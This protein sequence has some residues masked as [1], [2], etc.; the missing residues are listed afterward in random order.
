MQNLLNEDDFIQSPY[1]PWPL[2]R[3][4]YVIAIAQVVVLQLCV[5]F[6]IKDANGILMFLIYVLFPVITA[7]WM[8]TSNTATFL[9][10]RKIKIIG[11]LYL[12]L[13]FSITNLLI[14]SA[15]IVYRPTEFVFL[16]LWQQLLSG[17]FFFFLQFGLCVFVIFLI[18]RVIKS[19]LKQA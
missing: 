15:K 9:L 18:S 8:F 13:C 11:L 16:S 10:E 17:V 4:F 2:F 3:W 1:N 7:V 14:N 12:I 19:K 5:S 6:L